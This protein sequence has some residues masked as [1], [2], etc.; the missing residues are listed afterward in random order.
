MMNMLGVRHT[1]IGKS[2]EFIGLL[3]NT[4]FYSFSRRFSFGVEL[5]S[6][7][8]AQITTSTHAAVSMQHRRKWDNPDW[9]WTVAAD[10]AMERGEKNR[11][12]ACFPPGL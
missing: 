2:G 3:N 8:G 9:R 1:A 12:V 5:N 4:L 10:N 6:Q 7:I 11:M